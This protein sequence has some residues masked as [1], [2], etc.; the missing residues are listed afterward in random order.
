M[1]ESRASLRIACAVLVSTFTLG[2]FRAFSAE[3]TSGSLPLISPIFGDHMVLRRGKENH[4]W[5]W[6]KPGETV[7][8]EAGGRREKAVVGANGRWEIGIM[9]PAVGGPYTVRIND[10][11]QR[12]ELRDVLVGDVWLCGGQSNMELPLSRTRNGEEEI[13]NAN[14]PLLRLFTVKSQ[15]AYEPASTVTGS[16]KV[17]SPKTE[18]ARYAWQSNP[19]ATLFN[20]AGLPASPF[21]TEHWAEVTEKAKPF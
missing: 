8:V 13:K 3:Q 4:F 6:A 9:P 1:N 12:T 11:S 18:A 16:W 15:S 21:Q 14:H 2:Q 20:G 5:G 17:C 19:L 10:P 7:E